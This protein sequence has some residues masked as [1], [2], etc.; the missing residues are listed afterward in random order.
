MNIHIKYKVN[1][2]H[3]KKAEHNYIVIYKSKA[4]A[5]GSKHKSHPFTIIVQKL[6]WF[7]LLGQYKYKTFIYIFA[8]LDSLPSHFPII[9]VIQVDIYMTSEWTL[10]E[11]H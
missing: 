5:A 10:V 9:H 11:H 3:P 6:I 7:L 8:C 1:S 2:R 4:K